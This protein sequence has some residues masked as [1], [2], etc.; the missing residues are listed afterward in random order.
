MSKTNRS[1]RRDKRFMFGANLTVPTMKKS[2]FTLIELLVV[3][4]II[5]ILAAIALPVF[6]TVLQRGKLTNDMSNLRQIGIGLQAYENDNDSKMPP[7]GTAGT[8]I[9]S[10]ANSN[11][12]LLGYTG[13]SYQVWHSKFDPRSGAE[14][15][16]FPISYSINSKVLKPTS[17]GIQPGQWNGDFSSAVVATSKLVVAS[18]DFTGDPSNGITAWN[19]INNQANLV[20]AMTL[21]T[22]SKGMTLQGTFYKL[23]PVLFADSHVEMVQ[24]VNFLNSGGNQQNYLEWDPMVSVNPNTGTGGG[25]S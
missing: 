24:A 6:S 12:V 11:T 1:T 14:G 8:F 7:D 10:D 25:G 5:A 18:P 2:A 17:G 22:V 9:V 23:M 21:S 16:A 19:T 4:A 15:A 3:I 13:N 20:T